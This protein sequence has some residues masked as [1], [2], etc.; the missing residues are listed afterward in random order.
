[1][2]I[3]IMNINQNNKILWKQIKFMIEILYKITNKCKEI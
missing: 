2:K 1:M 3:F